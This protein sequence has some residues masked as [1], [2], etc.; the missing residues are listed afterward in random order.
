MLVLIEQ[1][2]IDKCAICGKPATKMVIRE[3]KAINNRKIKI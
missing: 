2:H 3:D 1:E